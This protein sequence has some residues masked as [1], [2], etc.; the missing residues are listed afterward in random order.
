MTKPTKEDILQLL[1]DNVYDYHVLPHYGMMS[2]WYIR[3]WELHEMV[4]EFLSDEME[5][6][7]E[8]SND[9]S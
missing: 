1:D 2:D 3:Y 8:E 9:D 4:A 6:G 5:C 7:H